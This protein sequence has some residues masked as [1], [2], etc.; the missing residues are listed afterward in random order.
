MGKARRLRPAR[1]A[2]KLVF[3]RHALGL[4]QT[5]MIR[6]LNLVDEI[7]QA[8]ISAYEHD[9]QEPPMIV[10]LRIARAINCTIEAIVDD[11]VDLPPA[12]QLPAKTRSDGHKRNRF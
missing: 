2:E 9:R 3:I 12:H 8:D 6:H 11:E 7:S 5:E 1:L 4:T 10:L